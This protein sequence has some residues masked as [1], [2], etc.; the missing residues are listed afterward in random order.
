MN[1]ALTYENNSEN[2]VNQNPSKFQ[3]WI[4]EIDSHF[5]YLWIK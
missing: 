1:N 3:Q 2:I 4:N 5:Y